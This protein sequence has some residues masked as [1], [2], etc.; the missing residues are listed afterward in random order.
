MIKALISDSDGTLVDTLYLI[1]HGQYE[2]ASEYL[3]SKGVALHDIPD[4]KTYETYI[5]KSV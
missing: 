4:Y 5:N 1:R 3:L 2:A